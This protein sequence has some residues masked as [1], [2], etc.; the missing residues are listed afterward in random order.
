CFPSGRRTRSDSRR[1][2]SGF[3]ASAP[4]WPATWRRPATT[5]ENATGCARPTPSP[6][7]LPTGCG[8]RSVEP[9]PRAPTARRQTSAPGRTAALST[10]RASNPR[11]ATIP[12]CTPRP[13]AWPRSPS[14][15]WRGW[16][17]S[18]TSHCRPSTGCE[19]SALGAVAEVH[20]TAAE[21]VLLL[22][23]QLEAGVS[24]ECGLAVAD[25]HRTHEEVALI[26]QPGVE[27]VCGKAR[28]ANGQVADGGRLQVADR[29]GVEAALE[30]GV[31]GRHR[32]QR[33]GVDDLVS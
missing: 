12:R 26:D 23:L 4:R 8:C 14:T 17:N 33:R 15:G 9:L 29:S 30:P 3:H 6:T 5:T 22:Q 2:G 13:H 18:P 32:V 25:D 7:I 19:G 16:P 28:A 31:A 11:N 1:F 24:G 10:P 20:D 27:R 21:P